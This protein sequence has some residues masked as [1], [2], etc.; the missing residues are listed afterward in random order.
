MMG[1]GL[2]DRLTEWAQ[3]NDAPVV[4]GR[5]ADRDE[6]T[7]MS[8]FGEEEPGSPM[9]AGSLIGADQSLSKCIEQALSDAGINPCAT[10]GWE[11]T[12]AV[13]CHS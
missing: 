6:W 1:A 11:Q 3:R 10:C 5:H 2:T 8:N 9:A 13:G 4:I 7:L 12:C